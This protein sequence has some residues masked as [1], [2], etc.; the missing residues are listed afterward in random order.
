M[1][2]AEPRPG[3][4]RWCGP[5]TPTASPVRGP[6]GL[7]GHTVTLRP[8]ISDQTS[9]HVPRHLHHQGH[10]GSDHDRDGQDVSQDVSQKLRP[11]HKKK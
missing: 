3:C 7:A 1:V 5:T 11:R 4:R 2:R 9:D 6:P 8:G 10:G